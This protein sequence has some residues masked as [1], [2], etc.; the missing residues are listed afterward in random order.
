V[1]RRIKN[2]GMREHLPP[3]EAQ[4]ART[5]AAPGESRVQYVG[6]ARIAPAQ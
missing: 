6:A 2:S 4:Q 1:V 3:A 5:P